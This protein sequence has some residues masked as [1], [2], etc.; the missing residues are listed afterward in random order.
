MEI[1]KKADDEENAEMR[2]AQVFS[3]CGFF[4]NK[5]V[6]RTFWEGRPYT[7]KR[8]TLVARGDTA[9]QQFVGI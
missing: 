8:K 3:F 4:S 2:E 1:M 9:G 5:I 6:A 7:I